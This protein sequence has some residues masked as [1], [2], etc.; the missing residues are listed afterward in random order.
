MAS[1]DSVDY[2][3]PASCHLPVA[4][5][6]TFDETAAPHPVLEFDDATSESVFFMGLMPGQYDGTSGLTVVIHWKFATFVGGQTCDWEVSFYRISDD[7][8]SIEA[9]AFATAKAVLA[10]E[11]SAAGEVDY[12]SIAFTNAEADG[13]QPNEQYVLRLTRDASGGTASPGDAQVSL[14][15]I[16]LT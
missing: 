1:G 9:Y 14:V 12:A 11:A 8:D 2:F 5:F 4:N 3:V 13:I 10:T 7:G 15:E 16:K 6:A